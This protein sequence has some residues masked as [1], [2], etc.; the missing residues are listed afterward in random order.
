MEEAVR[1]SGRD[2]SKIDGLVAAALAIR[3]SLFLSQ[4]EREYS[5]VQFKFASFGIF[6]TLTGDFSLTESHLVL[7]VC[8]SNGV[9]YQIPWWM[10]PDEITGVFGDGQQLPITLPCDQAGSQPL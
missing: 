9:V 1:L 3:D 6:Y 4:E 8:D 5:F 10:I 7:E 2:Q